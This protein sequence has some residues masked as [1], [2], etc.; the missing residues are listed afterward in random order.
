MINFSREKILFFLLLL[1][2]AFAVAQQ[3]TTISGRI[4]EKGSGETLIG[5]N[6][7]I[8]SLKTGTVSNA[9][10][11]Y[12]ITFS[13]DR[14]VEMVFSYV[15]FSAV[16]IRVKPGENAEKDIT[17]SPNVELKEVVITD[18]VL[19]KVSDNAQMSN[20]QL[21]VEYVKEIPALLGEKDVFKALQLLPGVQ[22]G[23][24]GSSGLYVRGGGPDQNLIILDDATVYN[25]NHLFGFFSLFNGDAL[26]SIELIKGG[27]PARYG[28]RLSSVV[29]MNMKDGN[30]EKISGEGGIGIIS[31]RLTLEGPIIKNKS[32]F[33]ISGRRTYIDALMRPFMNKENGT[34][35]YYFYDLNAKINYEFD[36]KNRLY[37][38]GYF[39]RDKFHFAEANNLTSNSSRFKAGMFWENATAT[40]RWNH[41]FSNKVFSN[42]SLIF[43][44]YGLNIYQEEEYD[45]S[46][47][48]LDYSSGIRDLGL[49]YD[50][51]YYPNTYHTIRYGMQ[52]TWHRFKPSAVVLEMTS[53]DD[54]VSEISS[55]H[56]LENSIYIED[57]WKWNRWRGNLGMRAF[58]FI[59]D[60]CHYI[61]PEPRVAVGFM[62]TE[63]SS[64]KASWTMMNQSVHL[65]SSTGMGLPTD[66]WVPSTKNIKP[67]KAWQAALGYARDLPK[68]LALTIEGYY[69]KS[70][71]VIGYRE[72]AS[73]MMINDPSD[74]N[75]FSWEENITAGQGWS[76]GAEILLQKKTGKWTGWVGYTLSWTQLQFDELNSGEKYYA[77]YDRRHDISIVNMHKIN[78]VFT[79]SCVWVFSS[80][81]AL[82]LPVETYDAISHDAGSNAYP[83]YNTSFYGPKNSFR[84]NPYHR[85]DVG[86]Q[87]HQKREKTVHTW[88]IGMYNMYNRHNPY[89]YYVE[90]NYITGDNQ[91]KQ[92]SLFPMIPSFSY[93]IKF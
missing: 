55:I 51:T 21:P 31:S 76:Y 4:T 30:R 84:L 24:E 15:G 38:S 75:Q 78:D 47:F 52:S 14:E 79:V 19:N 25:A 82:N 59:T 87:H 57:E 86:L 23:N 3:K 5:V 50:F 92:V 13:S 12:S 69:K 28:G 68:G 43:S 91:L 70:D 17:L 83:Y 88:E 49:K 46:R 66:L 1:V 20:F 63:L 36:K 44:N 62:L 9:Y 54:F 11:F 8:P 61:S 85:L 45:D 27:F 74:A 90:N 77:K 71:N 48:S 81:N 7:Y 93:S 60:S 37:L 41:V 40:L 42:A 56:T 80:G 39:G 53:T 73:F 89:F 22:K 64:M 6:V 35:G 10:G 34:F 67:Q 29:D 65:L 32:S 58:D 72:G 33:L 2:P 18:S 16:S 26:K